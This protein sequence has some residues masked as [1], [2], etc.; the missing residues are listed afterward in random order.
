MSEPTPRRKLALHWKVLIWMAAGVVVGI[1][2]QARLESLTWIGA[3]FAAAGPGLEGVR[4]TGVDGSSASP[5]AGKLA[6]GDVY[7]AALLHR[8]DATLETAVALNTPEDLRTQVLQRARIGQVVWLLAA[9]ADADDA[10]VTDWDDGE[11][12]MV[13][14]ALGIDPSSSLGLWLYPFALLS[15]IFIALL[16]MLIVPLVLSSIVVGVAG[17]GT[18]KEL[19]R[20]GGK[21]FAY[22]MGTSLAAIAVGQTL[23][24]VIEPGVGATLGL[25]P[26]QS[27][28]GG[29]SWKEFLE[30]ITRMVPTNVFG[31]FQD[32]GAMLSIIFFALILGFFITRTRE[33]HSSRMRETFESFLEVM[34]NMAKG[35]LALLPYGVFVLMV[36]VTAS[37][38][39]EPFK[40]LLWYMLTVTLA[41]VIHAAITLPLVLRFIGRLS[42]LRWA[43]AMS[44]ALMTAFSTSSSSMTLP[45]TLETVEERGRVS[46]KVSS[47]TLP[48]GATINMDGTA[49]YE[50]IGVIFLCQYYATV[51][52]SQALSLAQQA[53]IVVLALLASVG[54]AGIPSAGLVMMLTIL[55]ALGKP[56]EG[57]ALLLAVDRPL[58]MLRTVVNVWSDSCGAA[59]IAR[60]E[61]E[62]G[63]LAPVVGG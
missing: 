56:V 11:E 43:R 25:S 48:L 37:T 45:I 15:N 12:G 30:V 7:R 62:E 35:I 17:V 63:P 8:G 36:K 27:T 41:L 44:P 29:G 22:Y 53:F 33:P 38:G 58:D 61:G 23:V 49:L 32:N 3:R 50:C 10:P 55:S 14:L 9:R 28:I 42:P 18:M 54:A 4:V 26:S 2:M 13:A 19:R 52:P 24:N 20:L 57:A 16:K 40:A 47:F 34:M 31:A 21:T 6:I 60:S 51:D 1:L 59:V 5:A 46:K 39:L